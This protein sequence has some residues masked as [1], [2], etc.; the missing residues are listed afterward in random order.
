MHESYSLRT[1]KNGD[2][3]AVERVVE[4]TFSGLMGG[5][6]WRWKYLLNP[7]F[8]ASLV[9]VAEKD[10]RLIGCNHWLRRRFRISGSVEVEGVLAADVA[11]LPAYR[12]TGVGRSLLRFLRT[13][14]SA[15]KRRQAVIYM[16]ANPDLRKRFH[17]PVGGYVP[18]PDGTIGY[19]RVLNWDKAKKSAASFTQSVRTGKFQRRLEDVDLS[20]LFRVR[21]APPL[22]LH[23]GKDGVNVFEK[24]AAL[25]QK[26][27]L[28]VVSDVTTLSGIKANRG[29]AQKMLKAILTRKLR[30]GGKLWRIWALYRNTWV[31]QEVLGGKIT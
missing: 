22:F 17:S 13:S 11:V 6:S 27:D 14:N 1:L 7:S 9:A 15:R 28:V 20:V 10:G 23:I 25:T 19:T 29:A 4:T 30:V 16:F 24:D 31:L 3:A 8:D 2:E 18:A 5:K 21:S 12:R 26:R